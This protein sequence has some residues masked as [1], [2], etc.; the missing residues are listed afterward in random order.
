[1]L[2][3]GLVGLDSSHADHYVRLVAAERRWPGVRL[4]A[5]VDGEPDRRAELAAA[6]GL[7]LDAGDT[8]VPD[9]VGKVDAAIVAHRAGRRH[10]AATR[11]LL[12]AGVPVLVDKP[13]A[14]SVA[15]AR[16]TLDVAR[17]HGT[18]VTTA[19]AL[20]FAPEVAAAHAALASAA[21]G[22]VTPLV[23]G[24]PTAPPGPAASPPGLAVEVSGPAD[25][26]D[27]RDGLFFLGIHAVEAARA[28]VG[29]P[30]GSA[31]SPPVVTRSADGIVATTRLGGVDVR[32]LLLDPGAHPTAGFAV[33]VRTPRG[34]ER[35]EVALDADYLAPVVEHGLA[36]LAP[37]TTTTT[38]TAARTTAYPADDAGRI[39]DDAGRIAD[40]HATIL[41]DLALL[42]QVGAALRP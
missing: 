3:L 23:A 33:A 42:E 12:A 37:G 18:A 15:D 32:L 31:W 29:A 9:V 34:V 26:H 5:L 17:A 36:V 25:P 41:A 27:E 30:P 10:G 24:A 22:S 8:T 38:P 13:F 11:A 19:S 40:E 1:M 14:A 4:V 7:L 16:A 21:G 20:R 2:R 39:A 35:T 28:V 6:G